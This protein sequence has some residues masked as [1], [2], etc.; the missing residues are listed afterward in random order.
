VDK[1]QV[2]LGG[3]QVRMKNLE[4]YEFV[5]NVGGRNCGFVHEQCVG[6]NQAR[7]GLDGGDFGKGFRVAFARRDGQ[8]VMHWGG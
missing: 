6:P 7:G 8:L 1:F 3:A 5:A 2:K 4:L